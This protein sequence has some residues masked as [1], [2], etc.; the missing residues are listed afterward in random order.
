MEQ[1]L[2]IAS[3]DPQGGI[4]RCRLTG[5]GKLEL[6]EHIPLD[7]PMWLCREEK[8]LYALL[9]EPFP[10]ESGMAAFEIQPDGRLLPS[11]IL[12]PTLGTIGCH[13]LAAW[14]Q[15][16]AAHYTSGTVTRLN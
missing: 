15:V 3:C 7:R 8:Y 2:Y 13:A 1:L 5:G 4:L 6:M 10:A 9:R 16:Y 11:G 14:D 12:Q